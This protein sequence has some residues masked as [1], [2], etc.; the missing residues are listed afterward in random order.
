MKKTAF[1]FASV[2]IAMLSA[3]A[4]D[5]ASLPE[6]TDAPQ[7]ILRVENG[8]RSPLRLREEEPLLTTIGEQLEKWSTPGI[9]VAV[10]DDYEVQWARGFGIVEAGSD[11]P[12]TNTTLFQAGSISKPVAAILASILESDGQ[13]DLDQPIARYL[14]SWE[15]PENEF[16]ASNKITARQLMTHRAGFNTHSYFFES[17]EGMP[18]LNEVLRGEHG[19]PPAEVVMSPGAQNVY[20]NP[21]FVVL[22]QVIEDATGR[23][24]DE[25]SRQLLFEPLRMNN[26]SFAEPLDLELLARTA[27][28]HD[29]SGEMI[30]G[31]WKIAPAS[32]GGMWATAG[33][34][35]VLA[36]EIMAAWKGSDD[37]LIS[38]E[39]ARELFDAD[40]TGQ[41]LGFQ[42]SGEG[43]ALCAQHGG[44]MIGMRAWMMI[45][46]EIGKAGVVMA[47][48]AEGTMVLSQVMAA[49]GAEYKWPGYPVV[50][51][52]VALGDEKLDEYVGRYRYDSLPEYVMDI[53]STDGA[54]EGQVI[55]GSP[56]LI[57]ASSDE[58]V[59][60]HRDRGQELRFRRNEEG[61]V[62]AITFSIAGF[63]GST[64]TR[65]E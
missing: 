41:A 6:V 1:V 7:R 32:A 42:V 43:Q 49:I 44:G 35:A 59:F 14:K 30:E 17:E 51:E 63:S 50:R 55:E 11:Q 48:G 8:L 24:F 22:E 15:I 60:F 19:D 29:S 56:F 12:V 5:R 53:R 33:D 38:H 18:P 34:L 20:S 57:E 61:V 25:L 31:R 10:V 13:L 54:L 40:S 4:C 26:S 47:N 65:I 21:G 36:T 9:S 58:D 39:M 27:S 28:A 37:R 3:T 16:G 52:R 62:A 46:P 64:L 23:E 2:P 45:Y